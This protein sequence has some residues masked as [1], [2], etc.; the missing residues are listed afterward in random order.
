MPP[1]LTL[2]FVFD[3]GVMPINIVCGHVPEPVDELLVSFPFF[4]LKPTIF[5]QQ[6]G[7]LFPEFVLYHG[8]AVVVIDVR[9]EHRYAGGGWRPSPR[10]VVS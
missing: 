9:F 4:A 6:L 2:E 3:H 5:N 1:R 10:S 8:I 7:Y